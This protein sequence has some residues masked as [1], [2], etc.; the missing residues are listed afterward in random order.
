MKR[1]IACLVLGVLLAATPGGL[2]AAPVSPPEAAPQL[3]T[4]QE[5]GD[6]AA[7]IAQAN[8]FLRDHAD[9]PRAPRVAMDLLMFATLTGRDELADHARAALVVDYTTSAPGL[10]VLTTIKDVDAHAE[11]LENRIDAELEALTPQRA[12]KL[13]NAYTAAV[14]Y[15]RRRSETY[16]VRLPY[17]VKLVVLAREAGKE[18]DVAA[19]A[20]RALTGGQA[21]DEERA[22]AA[23]CME[24]GTP[25]LERVMLLQPYAGVTAARA[26]QKFYLG[27]LTDA[28]R[29]RPEVL[30]LRAQNHLDEAEYAKA[31]PLIE[32]LLAAKPA[33]AALPELL[34]WRSLALAATGPRGEAVKQLRELAEQHPGTAWA[35]GAPPLAEAIEN[36]D[37]NISAHTDLLLTIV[38]RLKKGLGSYELSLT[39]DGEGKN[40]SKILLAGVVGHWVEVQV[41]RGDKVLLAYRASD[42]DGALYA[43]ADRTIYHYKQSGAVPALTSFHLDRNP[44][45]GYVQHVG[46]GMNS[47][48]QATTGGLDE[49]LGSPV[50]STS[51]GLKDLLAYFASHGKLVGSVK[52]VNGG[53]AAQVL[54]PKADPAKS[55]VYDYF[56]SGDGSRL[57]LGQR[58]K[59]AVFAFHMGLAGEAAPVLPAWPEAKVVTEEMMDLAAIG[60]LM[61]QFMVMLQ[62]LR[63]EV[64][65]T[66]AAKSAGG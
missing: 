21:T 58:G 36:L 64:V 7:F 31:L 33:A 65:P 30:R 45:G 16:P 23:I 53:A 43:D 12:T 54:L 6:F 28:Q 4:F 13:I 46:M 25:P 24:P 62:S 61:N 51:A 57:T 39:D 38:G 34:Y 27:K 8:A 19:M 47:F 3:E 32:K 66:A 42:T 59:A 48:A 63:E 11:F 5:S 41:Y 22:W 18:A 55:V 2:R 40:I 17:A 9:S 37:Q 10:F 29:D 49:F 52:A 60:R 20:R 50:T 35:A 15:Y 44:E 14:A 1:I 56:V 26:M